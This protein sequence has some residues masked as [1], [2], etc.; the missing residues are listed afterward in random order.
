MEGRKEGKK[1]NEERDIKE[2][3]KERRKLFDIFKMNKVRFIFE[4]QIILMFIKLY[5]CIIFLMRFYEDWVCFGFEKRLY[6]Y[7]VQKLMKKE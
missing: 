6:V 5:I 7:D 1:V 3:R 4:N 2:I